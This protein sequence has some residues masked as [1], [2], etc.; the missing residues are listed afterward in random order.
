[1]T[2]VL[3]DC[4]LALEADVTT[5]LEGY[6]NV[7]GPLSGDM[8]MNGGDPTRI[9]YNVRPGDGQAD[10]TLPVGCVT[11][12]PASSAAILGVWA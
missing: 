12:D 9:Y 8:G 2:D 5:A 4:P 7:I 3:F 6:V 10:P 11:T 1:M